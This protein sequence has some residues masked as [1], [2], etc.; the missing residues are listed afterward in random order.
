HR[1]A[2]EGQSDQHRRKPENKRAPGALTKC[3]KWHV[4][5]PQLRSCRLS[6]IFLTQSLDEAVDSSTILND[7]R[8]AKTL[9]GFSI[10]NATQQPLAEGRRDQLTL[11]D[12][13]RG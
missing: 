4:P 10:A 1:R 6:R 11:L 2:R 8:I 12:G 9:L 5:G 13:A 7:F 3:L